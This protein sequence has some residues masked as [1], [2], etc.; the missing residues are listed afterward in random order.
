MADNKI[1]MPVSSGGIVSYS[2]SYHSKTVIKPGTV[3][4]LIILVLIL[5]ALLHQFGKGFLS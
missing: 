2:D 1:Q 3:I 4:F 5:E